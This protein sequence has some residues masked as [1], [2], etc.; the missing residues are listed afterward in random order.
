MI[1]T[2]TFEKMLNITNYYRKANQ[3]YNEVSFHTT[4]NGH[5]QKTL[6]TINAGE[7]WRKGNT[8]ILLVGMQTGTATTKN[9]MEI[10]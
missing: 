9:S 6:Q 3:K 8:P 10:P 1:S 2:N 5:H 7:V 4:Q